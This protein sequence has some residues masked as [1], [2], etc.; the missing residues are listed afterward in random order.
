MQVYVNYALGKRQTEFAADA[1]CLNQILK[2][3]Y[4]IYCRDERE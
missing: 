1:A 3:S 4:N 2:T